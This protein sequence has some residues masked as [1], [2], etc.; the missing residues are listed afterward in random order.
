MSPTTPLL[1]WSIR[2]KIKLLF[3]NVGS[4]L[5]ANLLIGCAGQ[6]TQADTL[7]FESHSPKIENQGKRHSSTIS[8]FVSQPQ[9]YMYKILVAE[10]AK[11]RGD[12]ALAAKYFFEVAVQTNDPQLAERATQA[13]LYAQQ[14][15][16]A[17]EAA[18][19]WMKIEPNNPHPRQIL[20]GVLLREKRPDEA[21]VHLDAMF[22]N[23]KDDPQ[24][25]G[26]LIS[27]LLEAQP[28]QTI[29][30]EL[31][32]KLVAKRPNN[33]VVLLTYARFLIRVEQLD[34]A[35]EVLRGLLNQNPDHA[36]AV[37]LY[38]LLL[39]MQGKQSLAL[40]WM[41]QALQKSPK[42]HEWRLMYARMLVDAEQF[43]E[44]IK[45]FKLLLSQ[46]PQQKGDILYALGVLSLQIE[47]PLAAKKYFMAL[48]DSGKKT[49]TARYYLGQ[50]AQEA[51][52]LKK[53]IYWYK[54]IE[55]GSN[56]L[57]AQARI[58]LILADQ[59]QLDKAIEHLR[60]VP[61][62]RE[63]DVIT[64]MQLEAELLVEQ[65]H[66][67]QAM[68]IY[69]R[70]LD[71]APDNTDMLYQRAMLH[72]NLGRIDLLERDFRRILELEPENAN[73]LNALGYSLTIHTDRYQ[74]AYELIKQALILK[75][76][77]YYILDSMGWVLYKM[78]D[79]AEAIAYLRKAQATQADPEMAAHLGEVLWVSGEREA[80]KDVWKKAQITFPDDE[81]L[82]EVVRRFLK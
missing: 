9:E 15:D 11:R 43:D 13:A 65:K 2:V 10:I 17:I 80:A 58:A 4:I 53:A 71:L 61:V 73:A 39:D 45:Q 31:M 35:V 77:D 23:F 34:K 25:L 76:T 50:I 74:E 79:Y 63:K 27:A 37:P 22:D 6:L 57:N 48:L 44:S 38:A 78:G 8:T 41:R 3:K 1:N 36:E 70:A 12:N 51:K 69:D 66:Y 54:Q 67:H 26:S 21:M 19:L 81:K 46:Y 59:G 7:A 55:G 49:D 60:S 52:D 72:E 29:A 16:L 5:I 82:R 75:P 33:P 40:Q 64:I 24:Q 20:G 32:E 56:Y 18:R 62:K 14:Y 30:L 47:E 68:D 42:Q 28:D